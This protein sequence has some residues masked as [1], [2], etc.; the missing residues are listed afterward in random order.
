LLATD[1]ANTFSDFKQIKPFFQQT[2]EGVY[3]FPLSFD[4]SNA[5]GLTSGEN[6][7]IQ[8]RISIS[9]ASFNRPYLSPLDR[10]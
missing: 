4:S 2:G 7:T 8:V 3:C 1:A 5:T 6:V 9:D 10:I